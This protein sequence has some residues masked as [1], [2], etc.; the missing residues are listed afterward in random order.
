MLQFAWACRILLFVSRTCCK[1][2]WGSN[3]LCWIDVK[4]KQ[5]SL[6]FLPGVV[7]LVCQKWFSVHHILL[8]STVILWVGVI[9]S[10][11]ATNMVWMTVTLG[12]IY[13]NYVINFPLTP[14]SAS[15]YN[16]D[17]SDVHSIQ[18]R[19]LLFWLSLYLLHK[20]S[21]E[22]RHSFFYRRLFFGRAHLKSHGTF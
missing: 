9:A 10:A 13:G 2:L 14:I 18:S 11:F 3:H 1:N 15:M 12:A 22:I 4:M 17:S 21:T 16:W 6:S 5:A 8:F 19:N 20:S 7:A